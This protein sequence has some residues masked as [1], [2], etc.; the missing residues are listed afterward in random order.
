MHTSF[1]PEHF[2]GLR[3]DIIKSEEHVSRL[4]VSMGD[5]ILVEKCEGLQGLLEDALCHLKW[6]ADRHSPGARFEL[7]KLR[8]HNVHIRAHGLKHQALVD[9]IGAAVFELVQ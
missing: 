1:L 5:T 7:G 8:G 4:E 2:L 9:A 3:F 6:I